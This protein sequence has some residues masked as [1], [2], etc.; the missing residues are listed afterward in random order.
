MFSGLGGR[1]RGPETNC[2]YHFRYT[3]LLQASQEEQNHFGSIL[4]WEISK[5]WNSTSLICLEKAGPKKLEGP[6]NEFLKILHMG[7]RSI[8]SM[9]LMLESLEQLE[10]PKL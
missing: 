4:F 10:T 8:K 6:F 3:K 2:I 1:A 5:S 7:S 9:K